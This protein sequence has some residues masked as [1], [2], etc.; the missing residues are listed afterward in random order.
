MTEQRTRLDARGERKAPTRDRRKHARRRSCPDVRNRHRPPAA[1]AGHRRDGFGQR[2]ED[3]ETDGKVDEQWV[4]S[5][6]QYH[7]AHTDRRGRRS[8]PARGVRGTEP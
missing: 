8:I 7:V 6:E 1:V 3:H 4:Q 5:A 2:G